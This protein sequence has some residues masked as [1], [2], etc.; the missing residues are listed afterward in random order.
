M[1]WILKDTVE[2]ITFVRVAVAP[3]LW[4]RPHCRNAHVRV[5]GD[6]MSQRLQLAFKCLRKQ[7]H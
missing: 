1:E 2:S 4:T 5:L 6:K 3:W 7:T